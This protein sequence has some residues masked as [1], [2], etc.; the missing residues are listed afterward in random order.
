VAW[1]Q[2]A[3]GISQPILTNTSTNLANLKVRWISSLRTF[4]ND[5]DAKIGLD[6]DQFPPPQRQYDE[7]MMDKIL[8]PDAFSDAD[9]NIINN[10]RLY[11]QAVTITELTTA[12][13]TRLDPFL[14]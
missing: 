13:G 8:W 14:M 10:C 7:Q 5:L 2:L 4:L 11:L 6:K 9:I 1:T 12:C 3:T